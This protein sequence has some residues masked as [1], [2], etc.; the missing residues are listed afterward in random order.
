MVLLVSVKHQLLTCVSNIYLFG[1][2]QNPH[3]THIAISDRVLHDLC[4][5][6]VLQAQLSHTSLGRKHAAT[7]SQASEL[8]LCPRFY[9]DKQIEV[10]SGRSTDLSFMDMASPDSCL[11]GLN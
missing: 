6:V 8:L 1:D 10:S 5:R 7:F 4:Q 3:V 2:P 9:H 11:H